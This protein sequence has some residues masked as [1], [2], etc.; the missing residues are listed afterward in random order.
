M[1]IVG[2]LVMVAIILPLFLVAVIPLGVVY[3]LIQRFYIP[4]TRKIQSFEG[5]LRSPMFAHF[6][7]TLNG[8]S[9]C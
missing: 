3:Y 1:W 7:E 5:A 2:A 6:S 9:E 4:G 8:L